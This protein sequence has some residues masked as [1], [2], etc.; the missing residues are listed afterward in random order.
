M[1]AGRTTLLDGVVFEIIPMKNA[2]EKA[3]DLPAG[4]LV[5]VTASPAKGMEA[6]VELS[7][8]LA[9]RG[10]RVIPHLSARLTKSRVELEGHVERL[11]D[12]GITRAFIVGG[13]ADDPG[14][15]FDAMDLIRALETIEHP[16]TELGV[17][18]YPEGHPVISGDLLDKA[19]I[20]KQPHASYIAT[21]MCFDSKRIASWLRDCRGAGVDLP[22]IVGIPGAIDTVKLMTIGA[23]I[24]VGT[25]LKYLAK[26]R[27]S[28]A[29]LMRPGHYTPDEL[30][31]D[32]APLAEDPAMNVVGLHLFTFNQVEGTLEWLEGVER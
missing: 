10:Y 29:K 3:V 5:S 2:F 7:E 12:S 24:G 11:A 16:F 27:K 19:L 22:V 31:A 25:S 17:T 15:F 20:E 13:D 14:E 1:T 18:G 30:I 23:R 6:T 9:A 32:L 4:A 8:Q 21:Q 26:N 28:V